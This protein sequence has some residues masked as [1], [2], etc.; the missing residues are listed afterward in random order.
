[1]NT[2]LEKILKKFNLIYGLAL[3]SLFVASVFLIAL[4]NYQSKVALAETIANIV[5][6][7]FKTNQLLNS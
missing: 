6:E 4:N 7:K 5:E 1:L 3:I 2:E